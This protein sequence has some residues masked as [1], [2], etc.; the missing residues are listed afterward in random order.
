M[1]F[2][3]DN[4]SVVKNVNFLGQI[5]TLYDLLIDLLGNAMRIINSTQTQLDFFNAMQILQTIISSM[6]TDITDQSNK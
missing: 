3:K 5:G 2:N 6:K 1:F 4:K